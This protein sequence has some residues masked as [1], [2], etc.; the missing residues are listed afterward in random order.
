MTHNLYLGSDLIPLA[1]VPSVDAIAAATASIWA[2]VQASDYPSR[3]KVI[4][5]QIVA[6][7]PDLVALQEV[8]LYRVQSPSDFQ[9]G[10]APNAT[11]VSLD[12]LA[13][14][15][16]ELDARGGGYRVAG[17][18]VNAEAELPV[19]DGAGGVFDLRLT[20]RDVILARDT[21]ETTGFV[22][23]PFPDKL[24]IAVGGAG[25]VSTSFVR[26]SSHVSASVGGMPFIFANGHLE[27]QL[28]S[29]IQM[30]QAQNLVD[31]LSPLP[32][33]MILA[34]DFNSA[35]GMNSYPLITRAFKDT[36]AQAAAGRPG[37]T[38]CQA[39][40]LRNPTSA[41]NER[42]DLILSRGPVRVKSVEVVGDDPVTGR[43]PTGLWPSDHFGVFARLEVVP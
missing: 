41:A 12:F 26:S 15:M 3:A 18:A 34:G 38:C 42:I 30:A 8:S 14:L 39:D 20:D 22:Q 33:P 1:T 29:S 40:D 6:F 13:I 32:G 27:V 16:A 19:N 21:V 7:T 9:P 28:F 17:E 24:T 5:D 36:F 25:G 37:F 11:E 31:V 35:P 2:N 10:M 23:S 43:T 4:A